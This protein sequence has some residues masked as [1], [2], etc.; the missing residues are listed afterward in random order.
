MVVALRIASR[1][2]SRGLSLATLCHCFT[3]VSSLHH[4]VFPLTMSLPSPLQA[5]RGQQQMV[6][7]AGSEA[8]VRDNL[9][10]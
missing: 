6:V 7:D 5:N 9:L 8:V 10:A 2:S 3:S 1:P 4:H